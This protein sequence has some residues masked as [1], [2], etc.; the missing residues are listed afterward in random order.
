MTASNFV[1]KIL[2]LPS[3]PDE[4]VHAG[5]SHVALK[6]LFRSA[7]PLRRVLRIREK[8]DWRASSVKIGQ[9][10]PHDEGIFDLNGLF[11]ARLSLLCD[12]CRRR[13]SFC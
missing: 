9:H 6:S 8:L 5:S 13:R 3:Q 2:A 12:W 11:S 10:L 1:F 4:L 7:A